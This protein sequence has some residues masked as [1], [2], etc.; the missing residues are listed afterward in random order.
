M[1]TIGENFFAKKDRRVTDDHKL[2]FF[3]YQE[4]STKIAKAFE[5]AEEI[6][7]DFFNN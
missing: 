1:K 7:E 3:M 6:R 5:N 2:Y 4:L